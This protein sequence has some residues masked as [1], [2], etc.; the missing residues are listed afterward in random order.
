MAVMERRLD[1]AVRALKGEFRLPYPEDGA[2]EFHRL[3][4]EA[5]APQPSD[6]DRTVIGGLRESGPA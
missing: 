2:A 3:W 6:G 5:G 1:L 4:A